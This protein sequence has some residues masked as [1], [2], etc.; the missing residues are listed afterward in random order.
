MNAVEPAVWWDNAHRHY[1]WTCP[2]C[3]GS[4]VNLGGVDEAKYRLAAHRQTCASGEQK[5]QR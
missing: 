4:G 1:G 5:A 2:S 3:G